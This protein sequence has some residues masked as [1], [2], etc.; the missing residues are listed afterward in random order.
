MKRISA[1]LPGRVLALLLTL[2]LLFTAGAVTAFADE[3]YPYQYPADGDKPYYELSMLAYEVDDGTSPPSSYYYGGVHRLLDAQGKQWLAYCAD[4]NVTEKFG[5]QYKAVPLSELATTQGSEKKLRAIIQNSYP[6]ITK[7]EMIQRMEAAGVTLNKDLIPCYEMVLTSAV[8]QAI[9]SYTNPDLKIKYSFASAYPWSVYDEQMRLYVLNFNEAYQYYDGT[10]DNWSEVFNAIKA[11]VPV[12]MDW[13]KSLPEQDAPTV[14]VDT[15]FDA[16]IETAGEEYSLQLFGL[17]ADLQAA[18]DLNVAVTANGEA[19]YTGPVTLVADGT[20]QVAFSSEKLT[21]G[22]EVTVELTGGK[23]YDDVVGYQA[24]TEDN[25]QPFIGNGQLTKPFTAQK[26]AT[27]PAKVQV[28]VQKV[29]DDDNNADG[30]RPASVTVHLYANDKDTG[31]TLTLNETNGWKGTFENL[32][33]TVGGVPISYTVKEEPV[34]GYDCTQKGDQQT[35]FTL[36]N[37]LARVITITPANLTIYVGGNEGY[38]SVV[39]EGSDPMDNNTSLPHP[40]FLIDAPDGVDPADLTFTSAAPVS[41]GSQEQKQW[42]V[43]YAGDTAEENGEPLYY[44]NP[45]HEGQENVRISYTKEGSTVEDDQ[46]EAA[47]VEELFSDYNTQFYADTPRAD[48]VWAEEENGTSYAIQQGVGNLRIRAVELGDGTPDTNPVYGVQSEE[49][50]ERLEADTAAVVADETTQYRLNRTTVEAPK[51]GI[52]LLF[53]DIYDKD[54]GQG[55]R[56]KTLIECSDKAIGPAASNVIRYHQAKY[57]DLVDQNNGNAWVKTVDESVKVVWAY[58]EGTDKNTKFTLLHFENLHR[59]NADGAKSGYSTGDIQA[60]DPENVNITNTDAGITF[61]VSS[62]GFS[63]FVLI[64]EKAK[65]AP[66]KEE[67]STTPAATP[68]PTPAPAKEAEPAAA[69]AVTTVAIP[70]TGDDSQPLVWVALVV[71]SGAVLAG[72]AVYR[73]KRSDK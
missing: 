38:E 11:D 65:P 58:P 39:S 6:F 70:Q 32:D 18:V 37:T 31:K 17:S 40:L 8:H 4:S 12:V 30:I 42:K 2:C 47:D 54:N 60:V 25:S 67:E 14:T 68:K 51:A 10:A 69:P 64:W 26:I 13:L 43:V 23:L 34:P 48:E 72:L 33:A 63:P 15:T 56:E 16:R 55:Q 19:V 41:E 52:G 3:E 61:E 57:L 29:W 66:E 7:D 9:Y 59:D 45:L 28:P 27:I 24:R 5:S 22:T 53:D 1:T 46:F 49:P 36:T 50:T 20:F 73:K 21:A 44:L 71:L 35:G 62:G